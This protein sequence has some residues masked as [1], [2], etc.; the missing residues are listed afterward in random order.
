MRGQFSLP[1]PRP[2]WFGRERKREKEQTEKEREKRRDFRV[3]S[4]TFSLNLRVI[5]P[6]NSGETRSK[7]DLHG[8]GYAWVPVL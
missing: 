1:Q 7:I 4:S 3:R 2:N 6:S 5:G 8:K